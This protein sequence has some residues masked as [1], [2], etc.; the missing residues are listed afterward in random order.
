MLRQIYPALTPT[1]AQVRAGQP[2][3]SRYRSFLTFHPQTELAEEACPTLLLHGTADTQVPLAANLPALER[4][5]KA[6]K[7]VLVQKLDGLNHKFQAPLGEQ[8]LTASTA[9]QPTAATDALETVG[10]WVMQQVK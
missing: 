5:L 4:G 3:N 8:A 9:V 7:R 6:S 10:E 1:A 2:T